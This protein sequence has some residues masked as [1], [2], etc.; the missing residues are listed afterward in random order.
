MNVIL[1][2]ATG[3]IGRLVTDE[4]LKAGHK[5][6]AF[7]RTPENLKIK[8]NSLRYHKGNVLEPKD[9]FEAVDGHDAV[10][11]ALGAGMSRKSIVRSQGTLNIVNAMQA[12]GIRRLVCQSTLGAH[13]SWSNLDFWWKYVM[14]GALLKPVFKDHEL[15]ETIVRASGLDWTIVRPSAF[16]NEPATGHFKKGFSPAERNLSLKIPSADVANFLC[17]Q[18]SDA[19]YIGRAVAISN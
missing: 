4:L 16:S 15:Q 14:F 10:V 2:G 8:D 13:E 12:K 1:F 9:V 3:N 7:A 5:V 6:T 11:I 18:T 17:S 19:A